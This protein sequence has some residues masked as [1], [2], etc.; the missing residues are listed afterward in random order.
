MRYRLL[1]AWILTVAALAAQSIDG[2]VVNSATGAAIPGADVTIFRDGG[3]VL[4]ATTDVHGSFHVSD[5]PEGAYTA[6][7]KAEGYRAIP[8]P[9][10]TQPFE[11]TRAA[12][13]PLEIKMRPNAK[14]SGRVINAAGKPVP[15]A[16]LQ[17]SSV[18]A[19][20]LLVFQANDKG[21]F[22]A[23]E[24]LPS[25]TWILC[26]GAP[27]SFPPPESPDGQRLGWAVTYYPH[28]AS[29]D[30]ASPVSVAAGGAVSELEIKLTTV[31]VYRLRGIVLDPRG[32]PAPAAHISLSAIDFL[33]PGEVN[34]TP[35]G[36]FE[37]P[38]VASGEYWLTSTLMLKGAAPLFGAR[39]LRVSGY[40]V[41][42]VKVQLTEPFAVQGKIELETP[43]GMPTPKLPAVD[44]N[45]RSKILVEMRM[46]NNTTALP[47]A[48]GVFT[49]KNEYPGAYQI[50][51][52]N[53]PA[54]YYL[55]SI[56]LGGRDA[57]ASDVEIDSGALPI[58]ISYKLHG[59]SVHGTVEN[60]ASGQV[61]L[62]PQDAPYRR[63]GFYHI[64]SCDAKG[65]YA[66]DNVRPG[67]YYA[68]AI[69]PGGTRPQVMRATI[70]QNVINQAAR[71]SV[72]AN[73]STLAD[74]RAMTQ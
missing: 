44:L 71:I 46:F 54:P 20:F 2:R 29:A 5:V 60:C 41:E 67:E 35:D 68:L 36:S 37:F 32:D 34:I 50:T 64:A 49:F 43:E 12:Q 63:D 10:I 72:R 6:C 21:E 14:I 55:D 7:F 56:T 18:G 62:V 39:R 42:S 26:A 70:D 66:I 8:E 33:G 59:G 15:K 31:P 1:T 30:L 25:G 19:G 27:E 9:C 4:A 73:E 61:W 51:P 58:G 28:E 69:P 74:L 45:S 53:A 57:I 38:S 17:V 24:D 22:Q 65:R 3:K 47:D 40:D 52:G 13:H 11:V 23:P 48:T 16:T